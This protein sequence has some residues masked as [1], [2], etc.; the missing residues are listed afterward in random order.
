M[1]TE[2]MVKFAQRGSKAV[3]VPCR[4]V[5][6]RRQLRHEVYSELEQMDD[7]IR[8]SSNSSSFRRFRNLLAWQPHDRTLFSDRSMQ[9]VLAVSRGDTDPRDFVLVYRSSV[10]ADGTDVGTMELAYRASTPTECVEILARLR[11]L[12]ML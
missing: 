5:V 9:D 8:N 4:L 1:P 6:E 2:Y 7:S 12:L 3:P 11:F 10:L